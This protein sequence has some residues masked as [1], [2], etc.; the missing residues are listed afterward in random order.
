M[1]FK[2]LFFSAT[3]NR[4][5]HSMRIILYNNWNYG[6]FVQFGIVTLPDAFHFILQQMRNKDFY[7]A[8]L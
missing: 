8:E 1:T 6:M 4:E 2:I 5:C 7:F 3:V